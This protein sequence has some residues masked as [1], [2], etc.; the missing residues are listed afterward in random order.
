MCPEEVELLRELTVLIPTCNR[1]LELERAIEYWRDTPVTVHILDGSEKPCFPVGVLTGVPTITYH[2]LPPTIGEHWM[3]NYSRRMRVASGLPTTK[4]SVICADDDFFSASGLKLAVSRIL[5]SSAVDAVVGICAEYKYGDSDLL[6]NLRYT[7]WRVGLKSQSDDVKDRVLDQ[8]GTFYLFYAVMRSEILRSV[9]SQTY[10]F[11][12]VHGKPHEYLFT[13]IA[14]AYC[15]VDVI[16]YV[17]WFK[18]VWVRNTS[19]VGEALEV[20]AADW[21]RE[22]KNRKEVKFILNHL[23]TG[24]ESAIATHDSSA[25]AKVIAKRYFAEITKLSE[26]AKFRK[27]NKILKRKVM[28]KLS[29][30][31]DSIKSSFNSVLPLRIR[32]ITGSVS[33]DPNRH[34][35]KNNFF[36]LNLLIAELSNTDIRFAENDFIRFEKL[37]LKPREEL[38][39]NVYE[40][41]GLPS[42]L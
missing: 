40:V 13:A 22:R 24:I 2:H 16:H 30:L 25:S 7:N 12:Y 28:S 17:I 14:K 38:R 36:V 26:T 27:F 20:G 34:L 39:L 1:P 4:V 33:P 10:K 23:A 11:S 6:W 18:K 41:G 21:F 29:F 8:S 5:D 37:L 15:K 32:V 19:N 42:I 9:V 35:T 3:E 31:P